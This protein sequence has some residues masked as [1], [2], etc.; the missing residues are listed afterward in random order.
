MIGLGYVGLPL[1]LQICRNGHSVLGLDIDVE[2]TTAINDGRSYIKHIPAEEIQAA[3]ASKALEAS[4][5]FSRVDKLDA[6][7]ICVPTPLTRNREPDI[8]YI[9]NTAKQIGPFV[10]PG[11]L[12]VLESTTYPGTTDTDLAPILEQLS[13]LKAGVDFHMAFSPE[14]EDPGNPKYKTADIPKV[15]GG[16]T[17]ECGNFA[18]QLYGRIG[19]S[20][21]PVSSATSAIPASLK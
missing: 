17:A 19:L 13:H 7:V 14:R 5:D 8:Q 21:V 2:K 3:R 1:A 16:L 15:V 9:T 4:T 6:V 18:V 12:I 10:Q 20:V 11:Q